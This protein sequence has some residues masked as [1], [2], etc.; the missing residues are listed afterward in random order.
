MDV[1]ITTGVSNEVFDQS[2]NEAVNGALTE[3][4]LGAIP[5]PVPAE[6]LHENSKGTSQQNA[7]PPPSNLSGKVALVTGASRGIGAGIAIE[8]G[9]RKASVIVNYVKGKSAAD[10]VVG[11][12]EKLGSKAIAV[13]ADVSKVPEI[14]KLFET[15]KAHFGKIDI[16]V[17][18][19]GTESF[20]KT[21]DITE[22]R[23]DFVF[24]LN[25]RAQFF[26]GQHAYKYC[27]PG[28]RL[29]LMSSIAAGLLGVADHSLYSGSKSA[30]N[31]ITKSFATDFGKR[32]MTCN[33]IAPG[34]VKSDMF[35]QVAWRYIPGADNSWTAD[36]IE[37]AMA[38][39]CPL[40]RCALPVD[41]ARVVAFLASQDG[42]WVNGNISRS[43]L[44]FPRVPRPVEPLFLSLIFVM[45]VAPTPS[46]LPYPSP[47]PFSPTSYPTTVVHY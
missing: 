38:N 16:V 3:S 13:Q 19:S 39:H 4:S 34:G 47:P 40:K 15:A 18:N 5:N 37:S 14:T 25:V 22:E 42:G 32:G 2:S 31:G 27:E 11:Q 21:E 20:D 41:V 12:I 33:A 44:P 6:A 45:I 35:T 23:F 10:E 7:V 9:A 43:P 17:S 46:S 24:G 28:G 30:V 29:I 36:E 26:V 1:T 8:L